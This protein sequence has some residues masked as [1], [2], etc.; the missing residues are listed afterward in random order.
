MS[1]VDPPM[2]KSQNSNDILL[3]SRRFRTEREQDWKTLEQLLKRAEG[4][5]LRN[6]SEKK[7]CCFLG[8]TDLPYP[9]FQLHAPPP[10]ITNS[11]NISK[12]FA[13]EPIFTFTVPAHHLPTSWGVSLRPTGLTQ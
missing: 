10:S 11:S 2:E 4:G 12:H 8:S 5:R 9:L 13:A 3:R 1:Q 6:L 7:S